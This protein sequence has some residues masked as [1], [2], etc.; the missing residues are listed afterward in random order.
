MYLVDSS[1]WIEFFSKD[2]NFEL[3]LIAPPHQIAI[4]LP[5]Y[6][7]VLQGIKEER[8]FQAVSRSLLSAYFVDNPLPL[9]RYEEAINI[10]RIGRKTG[11]TIR[12][13]V[14]CLIAACAIAHN[15]VVLHK[16]RDF[17]NIAGFSAL[18]VQE[19]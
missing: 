16:D 14:D 2:T 18:E 9:E 13:S 15:L 5:I 17:T 6:Q 7:E 8:A 10:Y 1:A 3:S 12:S 19:I 4:I 11:V